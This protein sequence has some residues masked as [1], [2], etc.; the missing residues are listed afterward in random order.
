MKPFS[1]APAGLLEALKPASDPKPACA[2][3]FNAQAGSYPS[4]I[5]SAFTHFKSHFGS[6]R[7]S[8]STGRGVFSSYL[9]SLHSFPI[10]CFLVFTRCSRGVLEDCCAVRAGSAPPPSPA[11]RDGAQMAG[12]GAD[13]CPSH[14]RACGGRRWYHEL[15]QRATKR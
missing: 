9:E 12:T 1:A 13:G 2:A 7:Q 15:P 11:A 4:L 6:T 10:F 14:G 3:A 8:Q 5:P